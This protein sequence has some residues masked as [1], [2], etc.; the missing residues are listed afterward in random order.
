MSLVD[1]YKQWSAHSHE[2]ALNAVHKEG[3]DEGFAAGKAQGN[4][5]EVQVEKDTSELEQKIADLTQQL[6]EVTAKSID[7]ERQLK[8]LKEAG[9]EPVNG[10]AGQTAE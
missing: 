4:T 10:S 8:K 7:L 3:Y 9:N 6:E 2:A 1:I 5:V